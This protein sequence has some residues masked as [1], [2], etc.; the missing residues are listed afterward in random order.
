M[1]AKFKFLHTLYDSKLLINDDYSKITIF[2]TK[3]KKYKTDFIDEGDDILKPY[4]TYLHNVYMYNVSGELYLYELYSTHSIIKADK[5]I[6]DI[7]NIEDETATD[8]VQTKI[9]NKKIVSKRL[10]KNVRYPNEDSEILNKEI[11]TEYDIIVF[12]NNNM[13]FSLSSLLDLKYESS[14]LKRTGMVYEENSP[15]FSEVDGNIFTFTDEDVECVLTVLNELDGTEF[16][17]NLSVVNIDDSEENNIYF[18]SV[19]N[20]NKVQEIQ[21]IQPLS[22]NLYIDGSKIILNEGD[23]LVIENL[24]N[25]DYFNCNSEYILDTILFLNPDH[26]PYLVRTYEVKYG[27]TYTPSGSDPIFRYA[28]LTIIK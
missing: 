19:A 22:K 2:S 11:E 4:D 5:L 6:L 1:N 25:N 28:Y 3:T 24:S 8:Y 9:F 13:K 15:E 20:I 26:N 12:K 16:T 18:S 10:L 14:F 21:E 7:K 17:I 27:I 23:E